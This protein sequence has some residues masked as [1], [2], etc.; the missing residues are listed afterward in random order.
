MRRKMRRG[1]EMEGAQNECGG[2]ADL[3]T[4]RTLTSVERRVLG[5]K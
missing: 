5:D 4:T 2:I 3:I 1:G